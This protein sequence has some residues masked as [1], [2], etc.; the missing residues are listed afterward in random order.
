MKR[1]QAFFTLTLLGGLTVVLPVAI[2][3]ILFQWLFRLVTTFI[4]PMTDWLISRA[5]M[6]EIVAD[7]LVVLI[8]LASCFAIGLLIKTGVG[9]WLHRWLDLTLARIAPGYKTIREIV[10]QFLGGDSQESLLNGQVCRARVFGLDSPA[11]TTAIVTATHPDGSYSVFVPTAPIPTS[12]M[13]Y[14]LP[15]T[16][17]ELLPHM[18]VEAAMRTVIACGAGSQIL[19]KP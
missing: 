11:S 10:S 17:V 6:R 1:L 14:H 18:T 16:C 13:V 5:E 3:V 7:G 12:G 2:L 19:D 8:I 4:Q 9:R 15:E